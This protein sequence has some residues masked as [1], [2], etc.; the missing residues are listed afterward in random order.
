MFLNKLKKKTEKNKFFFFHL[1]I[2][3]NL[4]KFIYLILVLPKTILFQKKKTNKTF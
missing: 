1:N 3:F 4:N 2:L